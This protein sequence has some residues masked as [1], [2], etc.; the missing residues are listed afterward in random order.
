MCALIHQRV[1]DLGK[2]TLIRLVPPELARALGRLSLHTLL[3][4]LIRR[5]DFV[6]D[7][8]DDLTVAVAQFRAAIPTSLRSI[9]VD[10]EGGMIVAA[11]M[12]LMS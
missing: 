10:P 11:P 7:F 2:I 6:P 5:T 12:A 1:Q 9:D 3:G 4:I 8:M